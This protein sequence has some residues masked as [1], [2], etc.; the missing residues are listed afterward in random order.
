MSLNSRM[1]L[2]AQRLAQS[3]LRWTTALEVTGLDSCSTRPWGLEKWIYCLCP[4]NAKIYAWYG[5]TGRNGKEDAKTVSLISTLC[6]FFFFPLLR[7]LK[8]KLNSGVK[9]REKM[10]HMRFYRYLVY[11]PLSTCVMIYKFNLHWAA[12]NQRPEII[13][14][15]SGNWNIFKAAAS[16]KRP[17]PPLLSGHGHL[18][19]LPTR[20]LLLKLN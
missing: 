2:T 11:S 15:N 1:D 14:E 5:L 3:V 20:V 13:V 6:F 19:A 10:Y 9:R 17:R 4:A 7:R 16:I 8:I 12:S 18:L